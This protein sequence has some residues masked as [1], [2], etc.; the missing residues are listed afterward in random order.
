MRAVDDSSPRYAAVLR[1]LQ[2]WKQLPESD[3]SRM[4][5]THYLITDDFR[6]MEEQGLLTMTFV[7]DEYIVAATLLGRLWLEQYTTEEQK[8][9]GV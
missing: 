7:G 5:R 9:H 1:L 4:L 3:L 2:A 8:K 6:E